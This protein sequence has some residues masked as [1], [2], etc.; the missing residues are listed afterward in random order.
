MVKDKEIIKLM[1]ERNEQ[2]MKALYTNY[3]SAIF[4]IITRTTKN[5]ELAEEV[6]QITML[7]A[8]DKIHTYKTEKSS[9]YTWLATIARNSALDKVRLKSYSNQNKT[10]SLDSTVYEVKSVNM[11]QSEM[12]VKKLVDGLDEKYSV[13]LRLVYLEGYSQKDASDKLSIPLGTVK[14]RLR[15]ALE[16]LRKELKKEKLLFMS[17]LIIA[18]LTLISA[19]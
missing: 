10:D 19:L 13:L 8:W 6:L 3:S 17:L 2:G 16:I 18:L 11:S 15:A 1:L 14:T 9:L 12:D 5:K 7:K 4:G